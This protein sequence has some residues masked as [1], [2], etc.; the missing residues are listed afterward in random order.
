MSLRRRLTLLVIAA[1]VA[2]LATL[3]IVVPRLVRDSL[4]D[5]LDDDLLGSGQFAAAA[6]LRQQLDGIDPSG[7]PP[8]ARASVDDAYVQLRT[9][10]G[11]VIAA[12]FVNPDLGERSF[13]DL[14]DAL[15]AGINEPFDV[16]SVDGDEPDH[17]RVVARPSRPINGTEIEVVVAMPTT[18]V[19]ATMARVERILLATSVV[20]IVV[21]GV[22]TLLLIGVGLRPLRR[23]ERSASII[24]NACDLG[25]RV[26]HPAQSTELGRLGDT[27][28]RMLGR[29][30][31]SFADQQ[32]TE[33][34][35]RR[36]AADASHELRTPLTSIRGYAELHRRGAQDPA[37]VARSMERIER[38]SERMDRLVEDLLLLARFDEGIPLQR[39]RVDLS[40]LVRDVVDDAKAVQPQRT[41][42]STAHPVDVIGDADRLTQA[43]SNLLANT[44]VHTP[45]TTPVEVIVESDGSTATVSVVD[46]G[47][48]LVDDAFNKVFDRFHRVDESRSSSRGGSG[49]GLA[50]TR[51]IIEAHNGEV[52][53]EP[54]PGGGATFIVRLPVLPLSDFSRFGDCD[55]IDAAT[56]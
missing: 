7:P 20:T 46:H 21:L 16:G 41:I 5:R 25:R 1:F 56:P 30:E 52:T 8:N 43:I 17:W 14:P 54:T 36:F 4:M 34:K 18:E 3:A 33:A 6:L 50:I 35:L 39:E 55:I 49:L 53:A 12:D 27:I 24:S 37:Q 31:S 29:L 44:R 28:N 51:S 45:E 15:P 32:A 48:G 9:T 22:L 10:D 38:E 26:D 40:A 2:G 11:A 23:M 13:P 19:D 47:R 42:V